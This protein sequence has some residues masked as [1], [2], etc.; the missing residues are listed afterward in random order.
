M[1]DYERVAKVIRYI[2]AHYQDQPTLKDLA[3]SVGLS[4]AH[5]HKLFTRWV[6][7]TPKEFLQHITFKHAKNLL[8][9]GSSVLDSSLNVGLSGPSRLHDLCLR[10]EA[11]TPGEVKSGGAGWTIH[12]GEAESPFGT[13]TIAQNPR[14]ICF[15][16]FEDGERVGESLRRLETDWFAAQLCRDDDSA[17]VT[18]NRIFRDPGSFTESHP[19]N[20]YV[21]AT[22][23]QLKVWRALMRVQRGSFSSYRRIAEEVGSPKAYRAVGSSVGKNPLSVIVP[24]HRI[25]QESGK[26]GGYHWG[27]TRKIAI[28]AYEFS[29][30]QAE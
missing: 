29:K 24:C 16:G 3:D 4:D 5:F 20:A 23:F 1:S 22:E 27:L 14:G 18:A 9:D 13:V 26:I 10:L 28:L 7:V 25:I 8:S 21:K 19:L 12:Y 17:A 15:L 6:G 2:E 11:A 30:E